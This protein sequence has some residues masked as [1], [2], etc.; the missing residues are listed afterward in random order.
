MDFKDLLVEFDRFGVRYAL[1]GGYAVGHHSKPRAT[2]DRATEARQMSAIADAARQN[3]ADTLAI[4]LEHTHAQT[5]LV[6]AD[7][8]C[9]LSRLLIR[10]YQACLPEAR[11]LL[12]EAAGTVAVKAAFAELREHDLVVLI[13]SSVFRIPEFRTRVELFRRGIK[14]IEHSNLERMAA[15]EV[16]HY[17]AALAYDPT[18]YRGVGH[19]L[20]ARMDVSAS[21]RIESEGELL[22]FDCRLEPAK[23][24]IGHFAG[25]KNVGSLFPIGEV[26]SEACDL[27][28]VHGRVK[29]YAFT[30]T[31]FRLN[32]PESPI[33]LLIERGRVVGTLDSSA[34]FAQVLAAIRADEGEVWLRE[35][36][37]G[38]NRAFSRERRVADV[39]AFER[40]CGV[41]LSLGARHGVY[42]K[43]HLDR[44]EARHHV[45][46]FVVT[47]RVLL[48]D[49][50]VYVEGAWQ[51][52]DA[53]RSDS[54]VTLARAVDGD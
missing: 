52:A 38:M 42:K 31:S 46:T 43:P 8:G 33:T 12:F 50:V 14:V 2:S 10:A 36:G 22:H 32:V 23:L 51:V 3:I 35:L 7:E 13:Q 26:F 6:I 15:H 24:N 34:D 28:C 25:L 47:S 29:I 40:V 9:E 17:V 49:Q 53:T 19:G 27:E 20:K 21:A 18:Y 41:H 39:G 45:D 37:F 4:A 48:D 54:P 5:A 11:L 16:E 44:R 1:L 30:D